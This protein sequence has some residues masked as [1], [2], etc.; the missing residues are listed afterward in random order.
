MAKTASRKTSNLKK[1]WFNYPRAGKGAFARWLPSWRF[2]VGTILACISLGVGMFLGLYVST[3]VPEP[4]DFAL[5]Q[6]TKIYYDDGKTEL[7]SLS[8]INRSVI[9]GEQIPEVMK[10]AVVAS[11]D[12]SFY[13]NNGISPK[14]VIRAL[15]NNIR[16]GATQGGST[17]TQQYAERYY[18]G[19]TTSLLGKAR[20]AILA[21]KIDGSQSKEEI[22]NNYLNTIYFG[23]G[24]YGVE[25]AAQAYFGISAK[26]LDLPQAALL[27]AV[28]PAPSAW[29][30]AINLAKAQQRYERVLK[31]MTEDKW[32]TADERDRAL[33]SF[34]ETITQRKA[35]YFAGTNGY[36][37]TVVKDELV[38]D[39]G[40]TEEQLSTG[41]YKIVSTFNKE[42]QRLLVD[43]VKNL[44]QDRP[45]NNHVG[46]YS[47]NPQNGEVY[48]LYGGPDFQQQQ[49]NDATQSRAQAGSTFKIFTLVGAI[50]KGIPMHQRFPAPATMK[51]PG[52]DQEISNNDYINYGSLDLVGMTKTSANTPFVNMNIEIGPQ[53]T[54]DTAVKMG[55]KR[56]TPG[57]ETN[58]GN[59]LGSASVTAKE[60][61]TAYSVVAGEGKLHQAHVVRTV[62]SPDGAK[63]YSGPTSGKQVISADTA[64]LATYAFES[65][66]SYGSAAADRIGVPTDRDY[67]AKS[68]TSTGPV[69]GWFIGYTPQM[70]T[71]VNMFQSGPNGEQETLTPFGGSSIIYGVTFPLDIWWDYTKPALAEMEAL[72]FPSVDKLLAA[73]LPKRTAPKVN[74]PQSVEEE[75]QETEEEA[76]SGEEQEANQNQSGEQT[77]TEQ[78]P[79]EN[80]DNSNKPANPTN[81]SGQ[82]K[83]GNNTGSTEKQTP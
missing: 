33:A 26:E 56:D 39:G 82:Q 80:Q 40:F 81:G 78:V 67:A 71:A 19:G 3:D 21:L 13:E 8:E 43:A 27:T 66:L 11:E 9:S 74:V 15:W 35:N 61:A 49:Q 37:M 38:N 45:A 20:E 58:V 79:N 32:I 34:P 70:V 18:L 83:P 63:V 53:T 29:D 68:G 1:R 22:L 14:G 55:I 72:D 73:Q 17:L 24:A 59:S 54:V 16:G 23:R 65:V 64:A 5:A 30:P 2:V 6:T 47:M 50:E 77:P 4:D 36:L 10:N 46:A 12:R 57:L 75:P 25:V 60:M 62:E 51:I 52:T 44:P 76:Q 28:I 69:S 42:K 7:G 31:L 41:G 48:A